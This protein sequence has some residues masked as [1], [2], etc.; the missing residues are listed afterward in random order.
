[1]SLATK[2]AGIRK[3]VLP[4]QI[5]MRR[6]RNQGIFRGAHK[7]I[8]GRFNTN[9]LRNCLLRD[10][11]RDEV[12]CR[13]YEVYNGRLNVIVIANDGKKMRDTLG[14]NG[15]ERLLVAVRQE[16][17]SNG[18]KRKVLYGWDWSEASTW[19]I[20]SQSCISL[21]IAEKRVGSTDWQIL[22][23]PKRLSGL[24]TRQEMRRERQPTIDVLNGKL[25]PHEHY[26]RWFTVTTSTS[27]GHTKKYIQYATGKGAEPMIHGFKGLDKVY[28]IFYRVNRGTEH[29]TVVNFYDREVKPEDYADP[30]KVAVVSRRCNRGYGWSKWKPLAIPEIIYA[31]G[32]SPSQQRDVDIRR[33]SNFLLE[34]YEAGHHLDLLLPNIVDREGCIRLRITGRSLAFKGY[35]DY[36]GKPVFGR[37]LAGQDRK[38]ISFWP[39]AEVRNS[40]PPIILDGHSV[41]QKNGDSWEIIRYNST[42]AYREMVASTSDYVNFCFRT[43]GSEVYPEEW[44]ARDGVRGQ[45]PIK[46][47]YKVIRGSLRSLEF[48]SLPPGVNHLYSR[49]RELQGR[50]KIVEF[51][52][53]ESDWQSGQSP[54]ALRPITLRLSDEVVALGRYTGFHINRWIPFWTLF[55]R[56]AKWRHAVNGNWISFDEIVRILRSDYLE[57]NYRDLTHQ[58]IESMFVYV[59]PEGN[60]GE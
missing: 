58:L 46:R 33:V 15:R 45:T 11:R 14:L 43:A 59:P 48:A 36:I 23:R 47:V 55:D 25:K 42:E 41:A 28:A 39:S 6:W 40:M 60:D 57:A 37:I 7:I 50:L 19:G 12:F 26:G 13:S 38:E 17:T 56:P 29:W 54:I 53:R 20:M 18:I 2:N 10:M 49:T 34:D 30:I 21:V 31:D 16:E 35:G 44:M 9:D 24:T 5:Q 3:T 32:R 51:W 4:A 52:H 8:E 27:D 22:R 1:M